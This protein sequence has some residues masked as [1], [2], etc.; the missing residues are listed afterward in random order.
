MSSHLSWAWRPGRVLVSPL[1]LPSLQELTLW[2]K[3]LKPDGGSNL[4]QA[5]RKIFTLEGLNSLVTVLGSW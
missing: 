1:R 2:V 3:N 5:L 4:L